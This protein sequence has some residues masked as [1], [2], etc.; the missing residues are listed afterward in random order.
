M[1]DRHPESAAGSPETPERVTE[2]RASRG[3]KGRAAADIRNLVF[4]GASHRTTP[5]SLL[6]SIALSPEEVA[7]ALP[8]I[9]ELA[10]LDEAML[11]ST[12]NRTEVYA[13]AKDVSGAAGALEAWLLGLS[14]RG[15]G[16][17]PEHVVHRHERDAV[18]H[19][20][21][22]AC[23]VDS[24]M[25]GETQ[26]AGQIESSLA[27]ARNAG[28][29]GGY[30]NQLIAAASRTCKRARTETAISAGVV[31]VAS[32]AAYLAQRVFG[33]L[34]RRTA[35][36]VG[37]GE[38]GRL[39][40]QHLQKRQPKR[41]AVA[42][43]TLAR[44]E[45]LAK[46]VNAEVVP[47]EERHSYLKETD[48]V[49]CATHSQEPLF[50]RETV[51]KAMKSR[52]S[53]MLLLIDI[54]L[55]RNVDPA[56]GELENVFL[57]DMEDLRRIVDQNLDRR[58]KELPAVEQIVQK[59]AEGFF[60]RLAGVQAGPLIRDLRG[61]F[62]E[63]RERELEKTLGKFSEEDRALAER[64]TRDMVQKLLHYPTVE[65]RSA[66]KSPDLNSE[67]LLWVRRLFGLDTDSERG[68]KK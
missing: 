20:L 41:I 24:M 4:V 43:R 52:A 54:S 22:V 46:A 44:A 37:A 7:E 28:T 14:R 2:E 12:C 66:A 42:N 56:A 18:D 25:L 48:L 39:V 63:I 26:I 45:E 59:E 8:V 15:H 40:A 34:E 33:D 19:L 53:R 3:K 68:E 57:N 17:S 30:L 6:E 51:A 49:V 9:R 65:I 60:R 13:T 67:K 11:L 62:E 50:T 21:Q 55:P 47:F 23:G 27:I 29:A 64:L 1:T 5:L 38:T 31:S 16:L 61:R 32:A 58:T 10:G 35:F 36:V